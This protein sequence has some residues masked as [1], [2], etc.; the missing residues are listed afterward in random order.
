VQG[1]RMMKLSRII[2]ILLFFFS[3]LA[4]PLAGWRS[5]RRFLPASIFMC[6]FLFIEDFVAEKLRWWVIYPNISAKLRGMTPFA[7]GPFFAGSI[8]ILKLTYGR[9]SLFFLLNLAVDVF[10]VYPFYTWFKKMGVWT[11]IKMNRIQLLLL[12][13]AKSVLMYG[14]HYFFIDKRTAHK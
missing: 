7:L 4:L 11:L 6:V 14:F 13:L 8:F 3:W 12:F 10:F 1:G 9:F 5:V 2:I